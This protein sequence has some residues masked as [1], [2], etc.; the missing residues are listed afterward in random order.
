M[1]DIALAAERLPIGVACLLKD[2]GAELLPRLTNNGGDLG[3]GHVEKDVMFSGKSAIKITVYQRYFNL[4]PGWAYRIT[5]NPKEGEYR[6]LRFAS[7]S[8]M[9]PRE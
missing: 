2:N 5:E 8:P 4:I 6:Y 3:E 7:G 1:H 9:G